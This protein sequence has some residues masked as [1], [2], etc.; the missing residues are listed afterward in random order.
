M[1]VSVYSKFDLGLPRSEGSCAFTVSLAGNCLA[2][3]TWIGR[4]A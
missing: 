3:A 2:S 1:I 4:L